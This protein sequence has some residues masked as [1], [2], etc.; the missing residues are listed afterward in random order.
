MT[1][2]FTMFFLRKKKKKIKKKKNKNEGN[3]SMEKNVPKKKLD[4]FLYLK[5]RIECDYSM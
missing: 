4:F 1:R 3:G 5:Q 2:E